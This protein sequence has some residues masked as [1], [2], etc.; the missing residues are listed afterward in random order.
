[1][2]RACCPECRLRCSPAAAMYLEACP[3]CGR[4]L[5]PL[6]GLRDL[7]GFRLLTPEALPPVV[8][9]SAAVAISLPLPDPAGRR[10]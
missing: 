6:P 2:I 8:P 10:T 9:E 5:Q 3:E 1:M 4:P 7:V